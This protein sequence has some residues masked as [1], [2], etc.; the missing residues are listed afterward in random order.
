MRGIENVVC[1]GANFQTHPLPQPDGEAAENGKIEIHHPGTAQNV[2]T[3]IAKGILRRGCESRGVEV[4][5]DA[6]IGE[7]RITN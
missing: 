4:F 3:G 6:L 2:A 7:G 5:V 1:F